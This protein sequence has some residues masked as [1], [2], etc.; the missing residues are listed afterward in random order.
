MS[1][2][3]THLLLFGA[4]GDLSKRMLLPSLYNLDADCLL[5][6]GLRIIATARS[7]FD[8]PAFVAVAAA[9]LDQF[10]EAERRSP[11]C[12]ARFL[13]RLTYVSLDASKPEAFAEL[14]AAVGD[15]AQVSIFLSTAPSLFGPTIAGLAA[16]GLAGPGARLALELGVPLLAEIPLYQGVREGGD[17]GSPVVIS[18]PDSAP[19][20]ALAALAERVDQG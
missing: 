16:A 13:A 9:A 8:T 10:V 1:D 5:P 15:S 3:C 20:K 7:E 4:T 6:D 17:S 12:D 19:A 11:V 14:A 2:P 18:A